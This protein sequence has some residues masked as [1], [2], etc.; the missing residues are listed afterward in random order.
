MIF[1]GI[2]RDVCEWQVEEEMSYIAEEQVRLHPM[3]EGGANTRRAE[4]ETPEGR[5]RI[6]KNGD[7][8]IETER[9]RISIVRIRR[10]GRDVQ[11]RKRTAGPKMKTA[12]T[13][14]EKGWRAI[15][16]ADEESFK[17]DEEDDRRN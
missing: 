5:D 11:A 8:K 12:G 16:G 1:V 3:R 14:T 2:P 4:T 6:M 10:F 17:D 13:Q 15:E 9:G 7:L